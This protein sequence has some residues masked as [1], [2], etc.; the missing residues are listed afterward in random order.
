MGE[1]EQGLARLPIGDWQVQLL[2]MTLFTAHRHRVGS[3]D[4]WNKVRARSPDT[5]IEKPGVG[6]RREMGQ[7][8]EGMLILGTEPGRIDWVLAADPRASS[9]VDPI[10]TIGSFPET[11]EE[12]CSVTRK[13]FSL[14]DCPS[15]RRLAFGAV[16][17]Y[18]VDTQ[19]IAVE[20]LTPY[21]RTVDLTLEPS[22]DLFFQINRPRES[23]TGIQGLRIN[24]LSK[25]SVVDVI[26]LWGSAAALPATVEH[27]GGQIACRLELDINTGVD[28]R[29]PLSRGKLPRVFKELV[30]LGKEIVTEGDIL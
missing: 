25:W 16:L 14:A 7:F 17:L 23:K 13:W 24:R 6:G 15:A 3:Q 1:S 21:L 9:S 30:D 12:L 2:R 4:W 20:Q 28:F 5:I 27:V 8:G 19:Q 22:L 18:C 26:Q 29:G 11:L 10:R